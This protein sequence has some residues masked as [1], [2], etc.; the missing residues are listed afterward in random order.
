MNH[1]TLSSDGE[2]ADDLLDITSDTDLAALVR[3]ELSAAAFTTLVERHYRPV[4]AYAR[5]IAHHRFAD[6]V[7]AE[8]F[9]R[10]WSKLS[11]GAGPTT[12]VRAYL[13]TTV[14]NALIDGSVKESRYVWSDDPAGHPA[15][16][17]GREH[18]DA[19]VDA[20]ALREALARILPRHRKII[21][22]S[23]LQDRPLAEVADRLSLSPNAAAVLK[24]RALQ[25]L[26]GVFLA[27]TASDDDRA[28]DD[29]RA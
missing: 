14:R 3:Q 24:H 12:S 7:T 15:P 20:L 16:S 1:L 8:S 22:L 17:D 6:D 25:S 29:G 18:W 4:Q 11:Q 13:R 26:R 19:V 5:T 28:G 27:A 2:N 9:A 10:L 23:V 21:E